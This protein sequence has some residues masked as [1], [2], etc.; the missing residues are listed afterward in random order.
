MDG[1]GGGVS[2]GA[3]EEVVEEGSG[4]GLG[5]QDRTRSR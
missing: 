4:K 2:G 1:G 3:G 5:R